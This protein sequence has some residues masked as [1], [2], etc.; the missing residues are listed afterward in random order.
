MTLSFQTHRAIWRYVALPITFVVATSQ[1][2]TLR[3]YDGVDG[4]ACSYFNKSVGQ[5]WRNPL[6]D[7]IDA[8]EVPNGPASY[9]QT[10]VKGTN[11]SRAIEWDLTALAQNWI[12]RTYPNNGLMLRWLG[13]KPSSVTKF[14][15]READDTSSHPTLTLVFSDGDIARL[16]PLGDATL[17]CSTVKGIGPGQ[18]LTVSR[19]NTVVMLFVLPESAGKKISRA[20]LRLTTTNRQFGDGVIGVYRVQIPGS[21]APRRSEG[22]A[23][24]YP[25]DSGIEN[26]PDVMLFSSF[27]TSS[28][29]QQWSSIS[30]G[31]KADIVDEDDALLFAPLSGKALRVWMVAN[32]HL[33]LHMTFAFKDKLGYEPEQ[34]YFRYYLRFA[35]D[36]RPGG[37][38]MPGFGG[39]Y[40][41][42]GWGGRK[43][44]G[45]NGW[46]MRGSFG[47]WSTKDNPMYGHTPLG[48]YAYHADMK[49]KYGE[50]WTWSNGLL[51]ALANNKWYCVEQYFKVN[52]PGHNDGILR[53]WIDGTLTFEKSNIRVRDIDEIKIEDLG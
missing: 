23:A 52:S 15:S 28:W 33:G 40:G 26:D 43:S 50:D 1:A 24:R 36:W 6:G 32:K 45:K 18:T 34:A 19:S 8:A 12:K 31:S 5:R 44:D 22:L 3:L 2:Q 37:G 53:V 38:K 39:T 25:N 29:K 4:A 7:W 41:R 35:N 49:S 9:A 51:G 30:T 46:S 16:S 27:N 10:P 17:D 13:G 48:T 11:Q 47:P 42:A 14:F 21:A 20:L